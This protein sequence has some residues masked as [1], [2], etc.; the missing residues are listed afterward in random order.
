MVLLF[1]MPIWHYCLGYIIAIL[2]LP[3]A[4]LQSQYKRMDYLH[5]KA[6]HI[7]FITSWFAGLFYLP[8]LLVYHREAH[9]KPEPDASILKAEFFKNQKLLFNAIMNPA[10]VISL[11]SGSYMLYLNQSFLAEKWM[12]FKLCF[13]LLVVFYHFLCKKLMNDFNRGHYR[14]TSFQL[15]LW[16]E[17]ATILLFAIVFLVVLKN[18]IDW[19]WALLFLVIFSIVIFSAVRLVKNARLKKK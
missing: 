8:R 18:T 4:L 1:F 9:D 17:V 12:W 10:M 7:I 2:L 11:L 3:F 16:N 5:I 15:R 6:I 14:F 13:V 19:L